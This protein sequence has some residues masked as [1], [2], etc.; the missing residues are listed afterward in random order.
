MVHTG[1]GKI[2]QTIDVRPAGPDPRALSARDDRSFADKVDAAIV[3]HRAALALP[4][5]AAGPR[6]IVSAHSLGAAL[7]TQYVLDNETKRPGDSILAYTF[8]SPRVGDQQFA[9]SYNGL[10]SVKTWRIHVKED[11][12]PNLPPDTWDFVH[13]NTGVEI[14]ASRNGVQDTVSCHHALQ[15]YQY[16]L[17]PAEYQVDDCKA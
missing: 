4:A 11:V 5:A 3:S 1:F 14:V 6:I 2:Y 12:V 17:D 15:T 16:L 13:V 7:L 9:N 10:A 8:A